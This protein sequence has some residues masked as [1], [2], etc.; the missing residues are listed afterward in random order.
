MEKVCDRDIGGV[1]Y[2][3]NNCGSLVED[4]RITTPK[5]LSK[6]RATPA[7]SDILPCPFCGYEAVAKVSAASE[8]AT[9]WVECTNYEQ[10]CIATRICP[11]ESHDATAA[12]AVET[13]NER[14]T[15][16]FFRWIEAELAKLKDEGHPQFD[17]RSAHR[18]AALIECRKQL[19]KLLNGMGVQ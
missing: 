19:R 5:M 2:Y 14:R 17:V 18:R 4:D 7:T 15:D 9:Y 8:P 6:N 13:W 1:T 10:D 12:K 11:F 3:C 16:G